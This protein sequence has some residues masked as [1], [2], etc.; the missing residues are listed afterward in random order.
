M[1]LLA[2]SAMLSLFL[3]ACSKSE[4]D[5]SS[6]SSDG[7]GGGGGGSHSAAADGARPVDDITKPFLS[8]KKLDNLVA[9][10]KDPETPFDA[11]QGATAF[12]A[13][14]KMKDFDAAARKHGFKDGTDFMDVWTRFH[15]AA[16]IAAIDDQNQKFVQD[17]QAIIKTAEEALKQKDLAPETRKIYEDQITQGKATIAAINQPREGDA[18]N[19]EDIALYRKHKAEVEKAI[20]EKKK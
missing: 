8:D 5:S 17:Q 16:A 6:K 4:D 19:A 3:A 12:N 1:R 14:S 10:L 15:G 7:G 20:T 9:A 18:M 13:G 2:I 11:V